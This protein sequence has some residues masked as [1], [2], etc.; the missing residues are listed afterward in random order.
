VVT[1]AYLA[2][3]LLLGLSQDDRMML[4]ALLRGRG[5]IGRMVAGRTSTPGA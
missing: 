2:A 5:R 4:G 1:M 3:V